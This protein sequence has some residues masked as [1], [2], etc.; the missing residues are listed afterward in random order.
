MKSEF[1]HSDRQSRRDKTLS[2]YISR[3]KI[4][5]NLDMIN[6]Y[7]DIIGAKGTELSLGKY[8]K[9]VSW[10]EYKDHSKIAYLLK[11]TN[12]IYSFKKFDKSYNKK[13]RVE[14][15]NIVKNFLDS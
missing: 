15:K 4:N 13:K 1:I 10:K 2:K 12:T 7:D 14:S 6:N 9:P 11:N 3:L 8:R 5:Y